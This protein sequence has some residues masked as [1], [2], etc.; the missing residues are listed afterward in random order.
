MHAKN[1]NA[2]CLDRQR[3]NSVQRHPTEDGKDWVI[4][5]LWLVSVTWAFGIGS[6]VHTRSRVVSTSSTFEYY[7]IRKEERVMRPRYIVHNDIHLFRFRHA[8]R[9]VSTQI[10][11]GVVDT[12]SEVVSRQRR[13]CGTKVSEVA[14]G[15][16]SWSPQTIWE[17]FR[18]R[19]RAT[20]NIWRIRQK[21]WRSYTPVC[22][23]H[24]KKL[25]TDFLHQSS[26]DYW[27]I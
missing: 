10:H 8:E 7:R 18:R 2:S 12:I 19:K 5:H 4:C 15:R 24:K 25:V 13:K 20:E 1:S 26:W 22:R 16:V 11:S 9:T 23:I 27:N 14:V 3:C 6:N 21:S 17:I